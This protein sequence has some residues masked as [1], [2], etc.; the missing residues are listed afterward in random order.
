MVYRSKP[1]LDLTDRAR[2]IARKYESTE[3][4]GDI[5]NITVE[6]QTILEEVGYKVIGLDQ[7]MHEDDPYARP[8]TWTKDVYLQE[9]TR[10]V[11]L[12]RTMNAPIDFHQ[13]KMGIHYAPYVPALITVI[14]RRQEDGIVERREAKP[15]RGEM[16][17]RTTGTMSENL[18]LAV[19]HGG[20]A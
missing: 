20:Q 4:S 11:L 8:Q 17:L 14:H 18:V 16:I 12:T 6:C 2:E 10:L 15:I 5:F 7:F 9:G 19:L 1:H 3:H 13:P